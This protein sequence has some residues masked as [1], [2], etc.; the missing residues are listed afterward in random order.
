M[1][2]SH[3]FTDRHPAIRRL[4]P[5][6]AALAVFLA[7]FALL[8]SAQAQPGSLQVQVMRKSMLRVCPRPE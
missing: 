2:H 6:Y 8:G 7:G 4:G 3:F 5:R 1:G